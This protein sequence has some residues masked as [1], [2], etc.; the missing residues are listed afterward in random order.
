MRKVALFALPLAGL[1]VL[2]AALLYPGLASFTDRRASAAIETPASDDADADVERQIADLLL[3]SYQTGQ[4]V[5]EDPHLW[6]LI[7]QVEPDP[8]IVLGR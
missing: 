7:R 1:A 2:L 6:E 4:A 5:D 8:T 3:T